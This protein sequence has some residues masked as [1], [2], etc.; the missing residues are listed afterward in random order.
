MDVNDRKNNNSFTSLIDPKG[1]FSA[2]K[3]KKHDYR[4]LVNPL[5]NEETY[6]TMMYY[7]V[8]VAEPAEKKDKFRSLP[9][10]GTSTLVLLW[11]TK[12][13]KRLGRVRLFR[14][15]S[16]V[17]DLTSLFTIVITLVLN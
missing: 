5:Y 14:Q 2:N 1:N 7:Y 15:I 3:M 11:C 4:N 10:L 8:R 6:D 16:K 17:G 13:Y 9:H 12:L